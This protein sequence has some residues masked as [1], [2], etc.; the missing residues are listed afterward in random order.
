MSHKIR[1]EMR[2]KKRNGTF[3]PVDFGKISNRIKYLVEGI[4]PNGSRIGPKLSID[5]NEIAKDVCG[6]IVDGIS[7]RQLD[8]FAA[9]L[10]AYRVGDHQDYDTLASRIIV[11]NHHKNTQNYRNFSDMVEALYHNT[12]RQGIHAPLVS[13]EFYDA[14]M[15]NKDR[16]DA[17]V[18]NNHKRDYEN[19]DYFGFKTLE[20]SYLLK[21]KTVTPTIQERY[22]H[23]L[24]RNA[25]SKYLDDIDEA[26]QYYEY[27][28]CGYFTHATPDLFNSGTCRPQLSSCFLAGMD[29]SIDGM[30]EAI[31]RLS[32]ISKWAGGIGIWLSDIRAYGSLIRGT[33]G[34]SS[35]IVTLLK[36]MNEFARHVNQGGKRKGSVATYIPPYHSDVF[37][38]LEM[39]RNQGHEE[40][41]ARDLFYALFIPDIFMRRV[42]RALTLK[43]VTGQSDIMWSLMCP[44]ECRGL[45]NVY[46]DEFD[47]LYTQYEE[48]GRYKRQV[49]ILDLWQAILDSLKETSLPYI[50]FKDHINRKSNQ[51]NIGVIKS[52]NLCCEI[53]E[54]SDHEEYAVCNLAS[55]NLKRMV[56]ADE[57]G[58]LFFDH[59][60][61]H[62]ITKVVIRGLNRVIDLNYYPI[63]QTKRS[64]FRHRPVG[65]GVQGLA[66]AFA[67]LRLP[68]ESQEAQQLN[69]DLFE[70]IYYSALKSSCELARERTEKLQKL[71]M[72]TLKELKTLSSDIEYYENY[73]EDLT[74]KNRKRFTEAEQRMKD[75]YTQDLE[76]SKTRINEII[77]QY[78]LNP[79]TNEYQ[80]MNLDYPQYLGAYSTFVGSPAHQGELSFD[81]W[82]V[83]PSGRWDFDALKEDIKKYGLRNSL[84][85]APMPTAS[86]AQI[87][88][89]NECFEP[90]K[91]NL[92]SR[93]VL[94][95]TFL[96]VNK[97]LQKDLS[98]LGLW[99]RNMKDKIMNA[100]GSIQN[101]A[102]IPDELKEL[103]KTAWEMSKKTLI[104]MA[105][106]R[107]AFIDQ[108]LSLN[109]FIEDP[110]DSLLST[111]L[112]YAWE[113]GLKTGSYYMRR[114][115][116][117]DPQKFSIDIAQ[118]QDKLKREIDPDN[119]ESQEF[120][121]LNL[122]DQE[123]ENLKSPKLFCTRDDPDCLACQG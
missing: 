20:K 122:T 3:Q 67:L 15:E 114:R 38:F 27:L 94:S 82:G 17:A 29:D 33:N 104:N 91:S 70:T 84:M 74:L 120:S 48:Q 83:E 87:L 102:E 5:H 22:Q 2:I 50:L 110:N 121:Q 78:D 37:D 58:M 24:M 86:T 56:Q 49:N 26:L 30:Y 109:H 9:E 81:M 75:R 76:R 11:S 45:N 108:S 117:V 40:V 95:G 51:K 118:Y 66:D 28:S 103:Y 60:L 99:D 25:Y 12:D 34:E 93:G 85:I 23:L 47:E 69:R 54:Y 55:I 41:R 43:R 65:T 63:P 10:C 119:P 1:S 59:D 105:A 44:D 115:T 88:R 92:Y 13:K 39:K 106:D 31:R 32:H 7:S 96:V 61:L 113:K 4:D 116:L 77:Q 53:V 101:I 19:L 112:M 21:I 42:Q 71:P 90:F 72:E 97:Y 46:G 64:N 36:V 68:F 107:S 79:Q 80:Y 14:V 16:L 62:K 100:K 123:K 57:D 98:D 18:N 52:S 8:E 73:L 89:N 111:I 35:G 6:Q